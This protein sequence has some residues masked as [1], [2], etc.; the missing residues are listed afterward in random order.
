LTKGQ[1]DLVETFQHNNF[2]QDITVFDGVLTTVS[3]D[4]TIKRNLTKK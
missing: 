3:Y 4:G 1:L 2:V